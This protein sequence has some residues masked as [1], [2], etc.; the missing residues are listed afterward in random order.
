MRD[1]L[2]AGQS[3]AEIAA[4]LHLSPH[5]VRVHVSRVLA[6]HGVPTRFA[7]VAATAARLAGGGALE[8]DAAHLAMLTQRQHAVVR[9]LV[10]G[11]SNA[12]IASRLAIAVRTV[13]KHLGGVMQRWGARGRAEVVAIAVGA[14]EPPAGR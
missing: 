14:M 7:L 11:A 2:L 8:L 12:E 4:R 9:H 10:T 6:A 3:N 13:E 5:T 1:L